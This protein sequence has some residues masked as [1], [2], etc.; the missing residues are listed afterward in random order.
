ME[1]N[2]WNAYVGLLPL[3]GAFAAWKRD[4]YFAALGAGALAVATFYPLPVWISGVSFSLPTRYLFF[5]AFAAAVLFA[6]ALEIRPLGRWTQAAVIALLLVD[7]V[8]RFLEWNRTYDPAPLREPPPALADLR[9][10]TG[11]ILRH[12][13]QLP[14]EVLP[15]L[16]LWGVAS[17]QGYDAMVPKAQREAIR[18]GAEVGGGRTVKILDPDHPSL[19]ALGMRFLIADRPIE[20]KKFRLIR[21]GTVRVYENPAAADVPPRS[22]PKAPLWVGLAVTLAGC[23]LSCVFAVRWSK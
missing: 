6:R 9:G 12:H 10:R 5:F 16:S 15:P 13:P 7:L 21:E 22:F 3:A 1:P 14:R 20:S 2:E 4:R 23:A 19:E 17:V 11:W 18:G 8:P